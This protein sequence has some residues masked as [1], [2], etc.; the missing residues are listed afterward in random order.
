M[1]FSTIQHVVMGHSVP[2]LHADWPRGA[3][4]AGVGPVRRG[5]LPPDPG[6]RF[7][8]P[9]PGL[10]LRRRLPRLDDV[11]MGPS[12]RCGRR[13]GVHLVNEIQN[14]V[15]GIRVLPRLHYAEHIG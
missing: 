1:T 3:L 12:P 15:R 14:W 5:D 7:G 11:V 9:L 10:N 6:H 2:G 8:L 4:S 13:H